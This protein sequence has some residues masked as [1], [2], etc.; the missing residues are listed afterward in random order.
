M[1]LLIVCVCQFT[2]LCNFLPI[3]A[4]PNVSTKTLKFPLEQV[5][6]ISFGKYRS[7]DYGWENDRRS[8]ISARGNVT[9]PIDKKI[10][11]KLNWYGTENTDWLKNLRADDIE[12]LDTTSMPLT[13]QG[14]R[15]VSRLTGLKHLSLEDTDIVD[16]DLLLISK[17]K[18]LITLRMT[19]TGITG[20]EFRSLCTLEK[21]E[22]IDAGFNNLNDKY[23]GDLRC[24]R[25]LQRLDLARSNLTEQSLL[26]M[27]DLK[28][29]KSL[30]VRG[31]RAITDKTVRLLPS[32]DTLSYIDLSESRI[33]G[34]SAQ[35]LSKFNNLRSMRLDGDRFGPLDRAKFAKFLPKCKVK[36]VVNHNN[37]PIEIFR[38]LH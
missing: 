4:T 22:A 15:N 35:Y 8:L 12:A 11:L 10:Y 28:G 27:K 1:A 2:W 19:R 29:I 24:L 20:K 18:N 13:S 32:A 31:N 5:G 26:S 9:V 23:L 6:Q 38:P 3:F 16:S 14:L 37:L 17:L 34:N 7:Y 25:N 36:Y 33:T 30:I 21:L